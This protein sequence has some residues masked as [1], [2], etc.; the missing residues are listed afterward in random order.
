MASTLKVD[1][2]GLEELAGEIGQSFRFHYFED[3]VRTYQLSPDK[4]AHGILPSLVAEVKGLYSDPFRES[5]IYEALLAI[6]SGPGREFEK[7]PILFDLVAWLRA[8]AD[9]RVNYMTDAVTFGAKE[10]FGILYEAFTIERM[11]VLD[12]VERVLKRKL[13]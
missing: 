6:Q 13:A 9:R 2:K 7:Y 11:E 5:F 1:Q 4:R 12:I 3:G 8:D 10:G